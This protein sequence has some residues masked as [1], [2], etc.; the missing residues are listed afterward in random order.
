MTLDKTE[1]SRFHHII[2]VAEQLFLVSDVDSTYVK[3]ISSEIGRMVSRHPL[4]DGR[5]HTSEEV[6]RYLLKAYLRKALGQF[7]RNDPLHR[8]LELIAQ[9]L[10]IF[11][12]EEEKALEQL[13]VREQW[14]EFVQHLKKHECQIR[15]WR[16]PYVTPNIFVYNRFYDMGPT[17][18]SQIMGLSISVV[19]TR[20]KM[21]KDIIPLMY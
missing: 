10:G 17:Q 11:K 20:L 8:S 14:L 6:I 12:V 9:N 5:N 4:V 2:E 19:R 7:K 21:I 3:S 13:I 1:T 15:G 16:E 18:I